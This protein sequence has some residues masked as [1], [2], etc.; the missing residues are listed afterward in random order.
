M[1]I[2]KTEVEIGLTYRQIINKKCAPVLFEHPTTE[3]AGSTTLKASLLFSSYVTQSYFRSLSLGFFIGNTR[4]IF[5]GL[6]YRWKGQVKYTRKYAVNLK[7]IMQKS[8]YTSLLLFFKKSL[9]LP[10]SNKLSNFHKYAQV[11]FFKATINL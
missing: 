4:R 2:I 1:E 3:F 8:N 9:S 5:T 7:R 11:L 6:I 10:Y